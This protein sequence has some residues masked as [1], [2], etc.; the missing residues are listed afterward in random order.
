M[1]EMVCNDAQ[2]LVD[3]FVNYDCDLEATNLFEHMVRILIWILTAS[4]GKETDFYQAFCVWNKTLPKTKISVKEMD[5]SIMSTRYFVI[6][7]QLHSRTLLKF[8]SRL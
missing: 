4:D 3:I 6:S 7:K 1:L 5:A 2:L 8:L